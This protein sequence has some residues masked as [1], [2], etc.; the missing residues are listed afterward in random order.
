MNSTSKYDE[1]LRFVGP[2]LA[3]L[4]PLSWSITILRHSEET[5]LAPARLVAV[6]R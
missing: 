2:V 6:P 1:V 5:R 4:L 3:C